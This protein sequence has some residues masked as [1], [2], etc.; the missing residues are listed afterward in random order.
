M[1]TAIAF[2]YLTITSRPL[3]LIFL[4]SV[5]TAYSGPL[6]TRVS[7]PA[8]SAVIDEMSEDIVV[9]CCCDVNEVRPYYLHNINSDY[10]IIVNLRSPSS[11]LFSSPLLSS[12]LTSF[13]VLIIHVIQC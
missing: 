6:N 11:P 13:S 2:S 10:R 8:S 3:L 1:I 7:T 4:G 12:L 5:D 9:K